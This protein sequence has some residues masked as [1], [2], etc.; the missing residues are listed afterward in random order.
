[1]AAFDF[2]NSP[3]TNDVHTENGVSFKW[4]GTVWKR[5]SGTGA[6]GPTGSTGSQGAT[7]P[8][9]AQGQKGAQAYISDSAPSSGITN[10]DLWWDSDSGD[11]SIYYDDGSGSPSA[12]WVEVGS[13]G[14]TG[15]TGAQGATGSGGSTGPTGPTG[16]TGSQGATGATGAQGA[17][18]SGGSTGA[19]GATGSTGA[20]GATGATGAQG[21]SGTNGAQGATGSGGSTGAQGATGSTGPTGN[22]G[23]QGAT[24]STGPTGA[25][26]AT[27]ST[28][29]TGPTGAQGATGPTGA[30][31]ASGSATISSNANNRVIT[32]G[33]GTNLVGESNLTFDG[34]TL[35]INKSSSSDYGRFEVKGPTADNI[36]TSDIRTKTIATFS[37]STPGTTAS[38]KG[39]GI[40]I[41]PISDRGCNYFFG[42]ANSSTNQEAQGDF[43][44][45]SGNFASSTVERLRIT[46]SGDI[47]LQGGKIYGDDTALP[48]FTIQNTSGNTNHSKIT[49]GE[50]VGSD[51]GGITFYTAGSST[52]TARMR[53]RG[54]NNFI[55]IL[56]SYTLRFN[57]GKLNI[58]HDGSHGYVTATTGILHLRSDDSI[59]LQDESGN[60]M[61]YGY[62]G[63]STELYYDGAK[64]AETASHG[65]HYYLAY[66]HKYENT[67]NT[68]ELRFT[69]AGV[70]RGSVY[71]DNGNTV[72]FL[73]PSGGWSARWHS[74]GKQT[75]HGD[76]WPNAN[77]T[78]DLGDNSYRWANIW[79]ND[80]QL[81]NEAKKDTGGNDVDGTW[82]DWTLQE[83]ED[84][85]YMINNRNGK[86]YS[87]K[88]EE[89]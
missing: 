59:R 64:K 33:S 68:I 11:F 52:S 35:L 42:V 74:T 31:G 69:T 76:I 60:P 57:D 62:N 27:G 41:K 21:A 14:P 26:G 53:I 37:G 24:G 6:Q 56:S 38:G 16:P 8:T 5:Q 73:N 70:R 9:G 51:N 7:G 19:Q 58:M 45:R 88:M 4:D 72:G 54:N 65:M 18:G 36:E 89:E 15:P 44:V 50:N 20:Q 32:G 61:L 22:T 17:T 66:Q 84:K 49:L 75:S 3:N 86:K 83:G 47:Q 77:N 23:A 80:L 13:T 39:A 48:T 25:Q 67:G 10:G 78:Y 30:Q 81:S 63:G 85:I 1:M 82:G 43:I 55:D 2:P 34:S 12:Q 28:G 40:V 46:S 79:V 71:A 29:P 87:L